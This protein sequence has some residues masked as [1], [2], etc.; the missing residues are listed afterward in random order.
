MASEILDELRLTNPNIYEIS[1]V[2][3]LC[4][5]SLEDKISSQKKFSKPRPL[6]KAKKSWTCGFLVEKSK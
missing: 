4:K 3:H 2:R 1:K 5:G 6:G